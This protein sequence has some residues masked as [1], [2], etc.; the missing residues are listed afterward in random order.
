MPRKR[1]MRD[2]GRRPAS[3]RWVCVGGH[4]KFK[5]WQLAGTGY[6]A[7]HCGHPTAL[8]PW[9]GERPDGTMITSGKDGTH[10]VA[11]RYL[12]DAKVAVELDHAGKRREIGLFAWWRRPDR[13]RTRRVVQA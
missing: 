1:T 3:E 12:D 10:G 9:Y 2:D 7:K 5:T 13:R 11:F 4:D 8:Y 6:Y